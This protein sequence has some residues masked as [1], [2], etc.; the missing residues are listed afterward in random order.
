MLNFA[1]IPHPHWK[2]NK[3][4]CLL[5]VLALS[6]GCLLAD[7]PEVTDLAR[8]ELRQADRQLA[9]VTKKTQR[10]LSDKNAQ[11]SFQQA[12]SAWLRFRDAE[13]SFRAS[14][15]SG[16]GSAYLTDYL[17]ISA[18]M[19]KERTKQLQQWIK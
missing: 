2:L 10:Q 11:K 19:T 12:Q 7:T 6:M 9:A 5:G 15:T 1:D 16:G 17:S 8:N 4:I 18:T 13:A 14:L 3:C